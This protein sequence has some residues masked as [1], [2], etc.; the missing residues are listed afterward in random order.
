MRLHYRSPVGENGRGYASWL[1]ALRG[2]SG[3]YLV[4]A[5]RSKSICAGGVSESG[6]L[7]SEIVRWFERRRA[8]RLLRPCDVVVAVKVRG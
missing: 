4:R 3:F 1:R 8:R 7:Y 5:L 2:R 6:L